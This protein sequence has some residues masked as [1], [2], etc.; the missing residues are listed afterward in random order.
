MEKDLEKMQQ[1][2]LVAMSKGEDVEKVINEHNE[3]IKKHYEKKYQF[4][5][6]LKFENTSKNPDPLYAKT[7]DSGFDFRASLFLP[8]T[9]APLE[10]A[11]IPTGLYFE[12]PDG[13]E[14][15]VRPR[16]GL[17]AKNGITVLNSPGTVDAG[18]RGEIKV[19]LVN[20]S[21]ESFTINNGDKIAQGVFAVVMNTSV[22]TLKKV[23]KINK[24][25]ER[26]SDGFGSTGKK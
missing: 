23:K 20:L 15:Q 16:S 3:K 1:E 24:N 19:I 13:Y 7:G 11:T 4:N 21:T 8:V 6:E 18:Y 12:I 22:T 14:I 26:G 9:I 10:R 5:V 17:A 25:T 2:I